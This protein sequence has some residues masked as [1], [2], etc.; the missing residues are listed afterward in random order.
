MLKIIM[1]WPEKIK[2]SRNPTLYFVNV[3]FWKV[4]IYNVRTGTSDWSRGV[5][6]Y[7]SSRATGSSVTSQLRVLRMK[8]HD[9]HFHALSTRRQTP[10]YLKS[11]CMIFI[12]VQV[13]VIFRDMKCKHRTTY[14]LKM[15]QTTFPHVTPLRLFWTVCMKKKVVGVS[16][17]CRITVKELTVP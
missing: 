16:L 8:V 13:H 5:Q 3:T 14:C 12:F 6:Y 1:L 17:V 2:L 7:C 10:D 11:T 4:Y 15:T 9:F